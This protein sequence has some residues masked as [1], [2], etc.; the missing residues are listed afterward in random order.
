[1]ASPPAQSPTSPR[2]GHRFLICP[3]AEL[4]RRQVAKLAAGL[5]AGPA[6]KV[7]R[8]VFWGD[9][10]PFPQGYWGELTTQNLFSTPTV[11]VLRRAESLKA[12]VWDRL[13]EAVRQ[14][15]S[16]VLPVFCLEGRWKDATQGAEARHERLGQ[17]LGVAPGQH[18]AQ[19]QLQELVVRERLGL[20]GELL[21]QALAVAQVVRGRGLGGHVDGKRRRLGCGCARLGGRAHAGLR[22]CPASCPALCPPPCNSA[23]S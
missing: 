5:G 7:A 17:G 1:M 2:R 12:E 15:A 13:D 18:L 4:L 10:D 19:Q 22:L 16:T 14:T 20:K 11:L 21:A 8:K 3:D 9:D 23:E 6:D